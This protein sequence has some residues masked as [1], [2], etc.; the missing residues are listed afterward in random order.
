MRLRAAATALF[1]L[2]AAPLAAAPAFAQTPTFPAGAAIGLVPP[3]G[4]RPSTRFAGF[5]DP[6]HLAS[7]TLA[8]FPAAAFR[9]MADGLTAEAMA[10]RGM[11]LISRE[12]VRVAGQ[13]AVLIAAE[14]GGVPLLMLLAHSAEVTALATGRAGSGS[15]AALRVAM[16]TLTFRAPPSLAEQVAALPFR[17][18]ELAGF[19]AL[20]TMGGNSV[21]LT[22][23]AGDPALSA[24]QPLFSIGRS[25]GQAPPPAEM[26]AFARQALAGA[27][28]LA[29]LRVT[30]HGPVTLGGT[31]WF[32]LRAEGETRGTPAQRIVAWQVIRPAGTGYI[33]AVLLVPAADAEAV[34]VEA[35]RVIAALRN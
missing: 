32:E 3:P 23:G 7:I 34:L 20:R 30:R 1:L 35:R 12:N 5:E 11:R 13:D 10:R 4:M 2:A 6:T 15:Q 22:R 27:P 29:G 19:R 9:P 28:G 31:E 8:E 33:R 24:S 26:E 25:V 21:V 14:Q 17:L 18:P 16:L